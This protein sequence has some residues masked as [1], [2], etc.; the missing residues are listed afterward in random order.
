P[1]AATVPEAE[2]M[3]AA[4]EASGVVYGTAFDQR[5]HAAHRRIRSINASGTLGTV[6]SV[7]IHYACW[8]PPDWD[9]D[10]WR[11]DPYRA[12]GGAFMD[13]APHGLDLVQYL[14]DDEIAEVRCL[15][16][17]RVH[18]YAVE[19]GAALVGS[20]AGGVL[21]LQHVSYNT[22]E[23]YPRRT[24][25]IIGTSAMAV[26]T[27]TLGQDAGGTLDLIR[28]A[29]GRRERIEIPPDEDRPPFLAQVEAFSDRLLGDEDAWPFPPGRDLRTMYLISAA[30]E[31]AGEKLERSAI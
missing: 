27:D 3:V 1:M 7:R 17:R 5:F 19:D 28:A 23:K 22:P 8:L 30:L 9:A 14:L 10:N 21:V 6:C 15:V 16:Q 4:C 29:D 11:A 24:L 31:D 12:G 25:E 26:A 18:D 2:A 13:L 20:T